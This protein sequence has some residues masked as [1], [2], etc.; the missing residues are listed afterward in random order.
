MA[1][2]ATLTRNPKA[3]AN[4]VYAN[5]NGNRDEASGDGWEYRGRGL[6]QLT[7]AEN[8]KAAERTLH[9]PYTI[10]PD[11][12]V[13]PQDAA[14]TAA[15]FWVDRG[16]KALADK[17]DIDGCTRAINGRAMLGKEDRRTRYAEALRALQ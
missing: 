12:V 6:F 2:A 11:F 3:L 4:R 16:C 8:Y 10:Q 7:G 15:W 14:L 9:R 13:L 5:K 17:D 1:D